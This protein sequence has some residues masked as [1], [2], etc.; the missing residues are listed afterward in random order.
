MPYPDGLTDH[1]RLIRIIAGL[2]DL[3]RRELIYGD[4][5]LAIEYFKRIDKEFERLFLDEKQ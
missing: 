1:D 3:L 4:R 5:E 2:I